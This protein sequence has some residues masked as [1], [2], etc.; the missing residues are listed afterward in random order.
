LIIKNRMLPRLRAIDFF[1]RE[2]GALPVNNDHGP[3]MDTYQRWQGEGLSP[4]LDPRDYDTWC[5]AFGLDWYSHRV[6]Y[7]ANLPMPY[8]EAVISETA[9]TITKRLPNGAVQEMN[10]GYN[11]CIPHELRPAVTVRAEWDS[12]KSCMAYD[13]PLPV[14]TDEQIIK[15]RQQCD[16]EEKCYITLA[17]GSLVGTIRDLLGFQDFVIKVYE[18]YKWLEDM[19]E[20]FCRAAE[21]QVKTFGENNIKIECVHFW[22]DICFKNGPMMNPEHFK[23]LVV[24]RY[25]RVVDLAHS[26]GYDV[27]S[28]DSDG[29][30]NALLPLWQRSG[31]NYLWPLE[32]QAGMDINKLQPDYADTMFFSGGIHKYR[33]VDGYDTIAA[34]LER[35][36]PAMKYGNYIPMLDHCVPADVSLKNYIAY[37]KLRGEILG[38]V[39]NGPEY[40]RLK[41]LFKL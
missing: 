24:P 8:Q 40:L 23:E 22:E 33:L 39:S 2:R 35:V 15:L 3:L 28:V 16:S 41:E 10:K 34:E 26:Y 1:R 5:D 21:W 14:A 38:L 4:E 36:Q 7:N 9:T 25:R 30:I 27:V 13:M 11:G 18:D 32:V 6:A 19:I 31:V 37:L 20:T 17:A 12:Y 29:N